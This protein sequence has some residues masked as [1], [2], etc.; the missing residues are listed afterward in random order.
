M[1]NARKSNIL[2]SCKKSSRHSITKITLVIEQITLLKNNTRY[3]FV[4]IIKVKLE[5]LVTFFCE[6][7]IT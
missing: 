3:T 5:K 1:H 4:N 6:T 2:K 7:S